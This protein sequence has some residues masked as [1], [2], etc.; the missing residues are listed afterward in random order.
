MA[1]SS[2][3]RLTSDP[4]EPG[5]LKADVERLL[6]VL[7]DDGVGIAPMNQAYAILAV[8]P[9]AIQRIFEGKRRGFEKR[10]GMFSNPQLSSEIHIMEPEKHAMVTELA[11]DLDFSFSVV[12][13]YREDHPLLQA[14]DPFVIETATKNG[15]LNML[16]NA[17]QFEDAMVEE[18]IRR[19]VAIFGSSANLSMQGTKYSLDEVDEPVRAAADIAF[20]YGRCRYENPH[21]HASSLIDFRDFTVIRIG[22]CFEILAQAFKDRFNMDLRITEDT[23]GKI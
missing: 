11:R 2:T 21:G 12:A 9:A 10:N 19:G 4:V 22:V 16:I 3:E 14:A 13:P 17:G 20:D 15:T 18:G 5:I 7:L 8:K 6:D 23:A 1:V